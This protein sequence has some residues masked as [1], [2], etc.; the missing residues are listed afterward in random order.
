MLDEGL[1]L[2]SIDIT[3]LEYIIRRHNLDFALLIYTSR[4]CSPGS[5]LNPGADV[6]M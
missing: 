2:F 5:P 1:I 4:P 3:Q 6:H